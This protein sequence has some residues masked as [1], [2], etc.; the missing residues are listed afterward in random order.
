MVNVFYSNVG[1]LQDAQ[2]EEYLELLPDKMKN[3]VVKYLRR[4]D[5]KTRLLARLMLLHSLKKESRTE[6][7]ALWKRDNHNKPYLPNWDFFNFSHSGDMVLFCHGKIPLGIDIEKKAAIQCE[8][9]LRYFH[10]AEIKMV[11][12]SPERQQAFYRIWVRKEAVLKAAG[13]GLVNELEQINCVPDSILYD[14]KTYYF[15]DLAFHAEY[16]S[17]LCCTEPQ[18]HLRMKKFH[19]AELKPAGQREGRPIC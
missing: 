14:G 13:C 12:E 16:A 19:A 1:E 7:L 8:D 3:E 11:D 4:I 15:H 5:Q 9:L 10:P 18:F 6:L 17:S 2:F